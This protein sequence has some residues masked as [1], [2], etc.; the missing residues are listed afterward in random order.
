MLVLA[1]AGVA[2]PAFVPPDAY[3]ARA[4]LYGAQAL[5]P[6][7]ALGAL[8]ASR[9]A[10][11]RDGPARFVVRDGAFTV[12]GSRAQL[13]WLVGQ[14]LFIALIGG[15]AVDGLVHRE[16]FEFAEAISVVMAVLG[17]LLC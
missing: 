14:V 10:Q 15:H 16:E 17:A 8:I 9:M 4:V 1:A 2:V 3:V 5:L 11:H 7:G 6:L 13:Y 12:P